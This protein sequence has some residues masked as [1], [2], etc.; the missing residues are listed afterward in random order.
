MKPMFSRRFTVVKYYGNELGVLN[1]VNGTNPAGVPP[2]LSVVPNPSSTLDSDILHCELQSKVTECEEIMMDE[3]QWGPR[4][5]SKIINDATMEAKD[6]NV[7][8]TVEDENKTVDDVD[9]SM[10]EST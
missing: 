5:T 9:A 3:I 1:N 2:L 4:V 7:Q 6:S 8:A 10:V